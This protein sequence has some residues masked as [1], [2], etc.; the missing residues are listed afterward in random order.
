MPNRISVCMAT[1]NGEK[2]I[3]E[4]LTSILN[5]LTEQDEVVV[6]DNGSTDKTL[7]IV[8]EMN[9]PRV[10]IVNF[11]AKKG[12]IWNFENA[13]NHAQGDYIFLADQDDIWEADRIQQAIQHLD[14]HL[15]T[16]CNCKIING[17]GEVSQKETFFEIKNSGPGILK[18]F[19]S[20]T[21]LGCCLGFKKELL[22]KILPFPSDIP[23]HDWWIGL[24]ASK[25]GSTYF[26]EKPG[27]SYRRHGENASTASEKSNSTPIHKFLF[28][29]SLLKALIS[30]NP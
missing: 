27:I 8:T 6:S 1:Y 16:V 14:K 13:L 29:F 26:I 20:N 15:L 10:R 17:N 22:P 18:N 23:M 19:V 21:F 25:Y 28:R 7:E 9:D 2:F 11:S 24:C 30:K 12:P 3:H 4:Q 5:Q